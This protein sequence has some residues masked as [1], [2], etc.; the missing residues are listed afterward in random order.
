MNGDSFSIRALFYSLTFNVKIKQ[1]MKDYGL[2]WAMVVGAVFY[3]YLYQYSYL[4]KYSLF[5]MLFLSYTKIKPSDLKVTKMHY[6]L[7]AIQW[8]VAM[9]TYFTINPFSP[10]LAQGLTLIIITPTATSAAVITMMLGGS[11][12]FIT[13]FLIPCNIIVAFVVPL[14]IGWLYP[15]LGHSYLETSLAI[16]QQVSMLL[17]LPLAIVWLI[18][19][20]SPKFN[21]RLSHFAGYTFYVWMLT[22]TVITANTIYTFRTNE[23]L[24]PQFGLLAGTATFVTASFLYYVGQKTGA[25]FGGR[26]VDGRQAL[27]QK[28]T[29]LSIWIAIAFMN[30]VVAIVPSF[31]VVW[32]NVLNSI[33]LIIYRKEQ[34]SKRTNPKIA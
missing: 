12:A 31:Y 24:T 33:E 27:G 25:Y 17:V 34:N 18:R 10:Y 21:D 23:Y 4:L 1:I 6:F 28:N 19:Y 30:P 5:I 20:F 14:L 3:P 29:V 26:R 11:I 32:Q 7:F 2:L 13:S 15:G 9:I 22:I 8:I 16:L